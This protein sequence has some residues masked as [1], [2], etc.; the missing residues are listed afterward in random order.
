MASTTLQPM[1][2]IFDLDGVLIDSSGI[3]DKAYRQVLREAGITEFDYRLVAGMR[4]RDAMDMLVDQAGITST[5]SQRAQ[6]AQRKTSLALEQLQK[7]NPLAPGCRETLEGLGNRLRL[8]L[9]TSASRESVAVFLATNRFHGLFESVLTG[10][11]V[12]RSKP[13]PE[14]YRRTCER[15]GLPPSQCVI[16]EDAP[17]GVEAGKAA[18][19]PVIGLQGTTSASAL[20]AAGAD[21]IIACLTDLLVMF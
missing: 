18:G 2:V 16:V 19:A 1:A 5:E 8:A 12:R 3:H 4:T 15:L 7:E 6:W 10:A 14:I 9:A 13:D 11:D 20:R 17:A 21:Q